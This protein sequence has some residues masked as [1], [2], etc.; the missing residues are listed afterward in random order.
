MLN[1]RMHV[2]LREL[3]GNIDNY[4]N[5]NYL[6]EKLGVSSRTIKRDVKELLG[7]VERNG[8][9]IE[10]SNQGYKIVVNDDELY[11]KYINETFK[12][13]EAVSNKQDNITKIVELILTNKFINQ[14]RISD[15]LFISRSTIS[16]LMIKVKS[17]LGEYG[18]L[19]NNKPHYGYILEGDEIAIR[20]CMVK[21]LSESDENNNI[22]VSSF[23][24]GY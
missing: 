19:L 4:I 14:D 15:E 10:A 18:I 12:N 20:N 8:A 6:A 24:Y 23:L 17:L 2:V 1:E 21:Y 11:D 16:K 22:K 9:T 13:G 3:S 7:I 5:S